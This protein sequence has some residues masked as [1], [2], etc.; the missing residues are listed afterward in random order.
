MKTLKIFHLFALITSILTLNNNLSNFLVPATLIS[1]IG[2]IGSVLFFLK[3]YNFNYLMIFWICS[4]FIYLKIGDFSLDLSQFFNFNLS[5]NIGVLSIG[6]N[7]QI[8]LFIFIK[9]ILLTKYINQNITIKPYTENSPLRKDDR[10]SF[11]SK[12]IKSNKVIGILNY[13]LDNLEYDNIIF[14]P[15]KSERMRK[16]GVILR[17]VNHSQKINATVTYDY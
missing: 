9:P 2:I 3:N 7:I 13:E 11:M 16:A 14:E 15:I 10:I 6:G 8:L 1:L 17:S 12:D 4:Q 5:L